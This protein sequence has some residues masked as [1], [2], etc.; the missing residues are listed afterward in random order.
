MQ[1][2]WG[3]EATL[4]AACAVFSAELFVISSLNDDCIHQIRTPAAWKCPAPERTLH[5][6]HYA[7][8]HYTSVVYSEKGM[9]AAQLELP[10][11]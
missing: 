8:F 7:E 3:D 11:N 4:L 9:L 5:I 10:A 2:T 6:A 1:V